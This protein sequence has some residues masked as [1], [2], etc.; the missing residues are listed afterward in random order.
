MVQGEGEQ[1]LHIV[2]PKGFQPGSGSCHHLILVA[3][4]QHL[5]AI[6]GAATLPL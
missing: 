5:G 3:Q 2:L 6:V 4:E 1:S